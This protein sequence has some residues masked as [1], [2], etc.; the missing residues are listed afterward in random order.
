MKSVPAR[1]A[2][3]AGSYV[4]CGSTIREHFPF[5]AGTSKTLPPFYRILLKAPQAKSAT[6][7]PSLLFEAKFF[8]APAPPPG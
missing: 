3:S 1:G 2:I 8:P 4:L 6:T 7:P 5:H